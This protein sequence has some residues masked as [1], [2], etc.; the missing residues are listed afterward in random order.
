MLSSLPPLS[1]AADAKMSPLGLQSL[2]EVSRFLRSV[3]LPSST[4]DDQGT[5]PD[6]ATRCRRLVIGSCKHVWTVV[7]FFL[8]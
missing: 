4:A 8:S 1:L 7:F 6:A 3:A 5:A 2:D